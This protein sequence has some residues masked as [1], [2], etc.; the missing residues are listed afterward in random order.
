MGIS[1]QPVS[2]LE[3]VVGE[4]EGGG[5]F[6]AKTGASSLFWKK[7]HEGVGLFPKL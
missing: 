4:L 7:A 5:Q 2:Q 3:G 6:R 1:H